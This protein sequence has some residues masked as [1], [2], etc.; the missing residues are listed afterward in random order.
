MTKPK[1][2]LFDLDE[3]LAESKQPITDEIRA[4]VSALA[5]TMPVGIISGGKFEVLVTNIGDRI[6]P[7]FRNGLYL[8]PTCGAAMYAWDGAYT[9]VYQEL[10]TSEEEAAIGAAITEAIEETGVIDLDVP[11]YGERVEL[12]GSQVTLS[13]LGQQAPIEAKKAWDPDR[14]KRPILREAIARRLPNFDVKTG[15]STS[16]DITK[17]GINKAYGVRKFAEHH[18]FLPE[19]MFYVGDALFPGGN[20]EVVKETGI[21][22]RQTSGPLETADIIRELLS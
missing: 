8:L 2:A 1:A 17:P 9:A 21:E 15:G 6:D 3:T 18:S 4:L 14:T 5:S 10:L 12:R 16:V 19:E 20:D 13:A 22:T 7:E 11:S